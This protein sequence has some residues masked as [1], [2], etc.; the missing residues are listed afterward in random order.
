[1]I[2]FIESIVETHSDE[3]N[4]LFTSLE[5]ALEG[6]M[7]YKDDLE[8]PIYLKTLNYFKELKEANKELKKA[9]KKK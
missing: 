4:E 7:V 1:M 6:N 2:K 5:S 8:N 9:E 3:E